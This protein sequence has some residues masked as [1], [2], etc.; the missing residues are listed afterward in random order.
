MSRYPNSPYRHNLPTSERRKI[1]YTISADAHARLRAY[2][3][4]TPG[5]SINQ[6]LIDAIE[7]QLWQWYGEAL[8]GYDPVAEQHFTKAKGE[9]FPRKPVD[10]EFP[11]GYDHEAPRTET[12]RPSFR[13]D[14][15][16]L[17]DWWGGIWHQLERYTYPGYALEEAVRSHLKR[18]E[19]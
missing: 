19:A 6:F 16:L 8:K 15:D 13:P 1:S 9:H 5:L 18:L 4:K 7:H 14:G 17:E 11:R 3:I 12:V 10:L 2:A